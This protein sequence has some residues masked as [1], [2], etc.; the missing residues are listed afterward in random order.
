M[1]IRKKTVAPAG[2]WKASIRTAPGRTKRAKRRELR[3]ET[4][5]RSSFRLDYPRTEIAL[6]H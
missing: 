3:A 6:S 4:N 5:L 1:E 2:K